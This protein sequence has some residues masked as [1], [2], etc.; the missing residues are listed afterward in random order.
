VTGAPGG[1]GATGPAGK[2]GSAGATGAAGKA[3][4]TGVTGAT[5]STGATGVAGAG[6]VGGG[7]AGSIGAKGFYMSLYAQATATPM[8]QAGTLSHFT[9]HFSAS[10]TKS[11]VVVVEKNG[12]ATSIACTVAEKA[13]YCT[14]NT[15]TVVFAASD[16]ILV[17][18]TYSGANGGTNPSWS[19]TFP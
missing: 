1:L 8:I 2:A 17:R 19:A 11:T 3:G 16:T 14:D 13:S 18:A 4:S 10:V 5:G 15:D 9:V 12:A 6:I 7:I